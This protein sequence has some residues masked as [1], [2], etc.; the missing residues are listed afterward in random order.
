MLKYELR[1]K[2]QDKKDDVPHYTAKNYAALLNKI[3]QIAKAI[4][5][6]SKTEILSIS[7]Q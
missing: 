6:V 2:G 7:L 1:C 4:D 5:T 3:C